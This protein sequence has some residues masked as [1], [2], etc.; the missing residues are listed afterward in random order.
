M[1]SEIFDLERWLEWFSSL[2]RSFVFLLILPFVV[3]IVGLWSAIAEKEEE[4]DAK[5]ASAGA[6]RRVAERRQR[7]RRQEDAGRLSG[8]RG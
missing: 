6:E 8:S 4:R 5:T 1:L 2:D 3:A 7:R